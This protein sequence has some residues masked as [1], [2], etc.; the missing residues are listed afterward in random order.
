MSRWQMLYR[1]PLHPEA[2]VYRR[3][4]GEELDGIVRFFGEDETYYE[5]S[6]SVLEEA[7]RNPGFLHGT[8]V[9]VRRLS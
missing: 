2:R 8:E 4:E 7:E 5:I 9:S 1:D 3:A 6:L